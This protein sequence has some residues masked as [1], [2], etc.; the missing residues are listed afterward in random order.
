MPTQNS[1]LGVAGEHYVLSCLLRQGYIAGFA[2]PGT[3][4]I[5]IM[6]YDGRC[7]VHCNIQVKRRNPNRPNGGWVMSRKHGTP[8]DKLF[9]CLV[10]FPTT[11]A[12]RYDVYVM[13]SDVVAT[14]LLTG[15]GLWLS[16]LGRNGQAHRDNDV[17]VLLQDYS[18][19]GEVAMQEYGAGWLEPYRNR[20]DLLT[21]G[22]PLVPSELGPQQ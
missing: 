13:P 11:E 1:L 15:H 8:I 2:P 22:Q 14:V 3:P 18:R 12:G 20:W 6:V 7:E 9:F 16:Q 19:R 5:D 17:R 10:S 21:P 4:S